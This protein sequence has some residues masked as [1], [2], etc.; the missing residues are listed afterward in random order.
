MTKYSHLPT[1]LLS[2][3]VLHPTQCAP[4]NEDDTEHFV[5]CPP[6]DSSFTLTIL[7]VS[8]MAWYMV[9]GT[10]TRHHV[11]RA[12]S[13]RQTSADL[14]YLA[15]ETK[16]LLKWHPRATPSIPHDGWSTP[17]PK[18]SQPLSLMQRRQHAATEWSAPPSAAVK[19]MNSPCATYSSPMKTGTG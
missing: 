18:I 5:H 14:S 10:H 9:H 7:I 12:R 19:S 6:H 3:I 2:S 11:M 8:V 15:I 4:R 17:A 1:I 13:K 16:L